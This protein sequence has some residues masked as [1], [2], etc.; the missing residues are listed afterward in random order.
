MKT[1]TTTPSRPITEIVTSYEAAC[2]LT[3][4]TPLTIED[5]AKHPAKH[6]DSVFASHQLN[7]IADALNGPN[8]FDYSKANEYKY[9][10]YFWWNVNRA[11]GPGFS[12]VD[13]YY[14]YS[15]SRVGAR[16]SFRTRDFARFAGTHFEDIYNRFLSPYRPK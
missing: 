10:P 11:G 9:Y 15:R 1:E 13:Y 8:E 7:V 5:F 4:T 2:E 16:H 14:D 12:Y 6:R 3:G